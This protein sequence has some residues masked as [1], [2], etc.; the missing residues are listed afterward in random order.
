VPLT[1]RHA[2]RPDNLRIFPSVRFYHWTDPTCRGDQ[3][4]MVH[5]VFHLMRLPWSPFNRASV[6]GNARTGPVDTDRQLH[7]GCSFS[8]P[9]ERGKM[10]IFS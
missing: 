5:E 1:R 7:D 3:A 10:L 2:R 6:L 9:P 4:F 8:L